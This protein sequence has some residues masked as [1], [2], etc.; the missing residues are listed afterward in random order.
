VRADH[1]VEPAED[2]ALQLQML[3][4]R[5]DHQVGIG[6]PVDVDDDLD[7]GQQV[8]ALGTGQLAPGHR[9]RRRPF[10]DLPGVTGAVGIDLH[11]DHGQAVPAITSAMPEPIVP[12]PTTPHGPDLSVIAKPFSSR[13]MTPRTGIGLRIVTPGRPA[14]P[15]GLNVGHATPEAST[16]RGGWGSRQGRASLYAVRLVIARCSVD[17]AGV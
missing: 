4:H 10:E 9:P 12:R 14:P 5:L 11:P 15:V 13:P 1:R 7:P 2:L 8:V 3:G 16:R 17:Y 6:Q